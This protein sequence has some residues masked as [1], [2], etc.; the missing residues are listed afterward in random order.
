L[1]TGKKVCRRVDHTGSA[2]LRKLGCDLP[3][4]L[5]VLFVVG[6][7]TKCKYVKNFIAIFFIC[8]TVIH[9]LST[10]DTDRYTPHF[11]SRRGPLYAAFRQPTQTVNSSVRLL[12]IFASREMPILKNVLQMQRSNYHMIASGP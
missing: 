1:S 7:Y 3:Q 11:D 4:R 6:R 5:H 9:C 8:E 10:A 12:G 2:V